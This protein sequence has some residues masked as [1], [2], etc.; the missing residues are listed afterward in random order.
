MHRVDHAYVNWYVI[1]DGSELTLVD[2][3]LPRSWAALERLLRLMGRPLSAVSALVLT[4]AHFDHVGMA[5]RLCHR[6]VPVLLHEG[7][8]ELPGHPLRYDHEAA[9]RRY[10]RCGFG[11]VL[12]AMTAA[13]APMI[14]GRHPTATFA[15]GQTLDVPGTTR[16]IFTPGH[17][18]GHCALHLPQSGT[19]LSGDALV[20]FD[21]YSGCAGP[22]LVARGA[23]ASSATARASLDRLAQVEADTVLPG[24][25]DPWRGSLAAAV[26]RAQRAPVL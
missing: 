11:R 10:L 2:A 26:E 7:D 25:G 21:P 12:A 3:G 22:R 6:G 8:V 19:L 14:R 9:R 17:T 5:G 24:N 16:A 23:T 18:Y 20:T 1:E 4:H 13:G 15:D